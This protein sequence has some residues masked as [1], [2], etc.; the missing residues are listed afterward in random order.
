[1]QPL[2]TSLNVGVLIQPRTLNSAIRLIEP[3]LDGMRVSMASVWRLSQGP[4]EFWN[5]QLRLC[6]KK[7][8]TDLTI[9]NVSCSN[10]DIIDVLLMPTQRSSS[11]NLGAESRSS[12][13]SV[14]KS[15]KSR[16]R[17]LAA[18]EDRGGHCKK[19]P[20]VFIGTWIIF[21]TVEKVEDERKM[22]RYRDEKAMR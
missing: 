4:T 19:K 20:Q 21:G 14:L 2:A 8:R 6:N 17:A 13:K 11:I 5:L 10:V 16:D 15:P 9:S 3:I 12:L 7:T 1:M 22:R 18:R